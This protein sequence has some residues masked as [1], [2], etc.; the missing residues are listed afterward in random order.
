MPNRWELKLNAAAESESHLAYLCLGSNI[1]PESNLRKAIQILKERAVVSVVS[2]AWETR[3]VGTAEAPNFLNACAGLVTSLT[4]SGLTEELIRPIETAMGRDRTSD[5]N[6]PRPIDIDLI[7]YDDQPLRIE[8]WQEA[9]MLVPLAELIPD[10]LHPVSR[11]SLAQAASEARRRIW[12]QPRP[13]VLDGA[14][15]P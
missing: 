5:K 4:P 3:A 10:F 12:I 6:A 13:E 11:E 2:N 9:F 14:P 1:R 15:I 7:L 8:Y